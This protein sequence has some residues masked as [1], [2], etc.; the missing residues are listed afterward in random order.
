MGNTSDYLAT[1]IAWNE[2]EILDQD[3]TPAD[4]VAALERL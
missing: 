4:I 3:M 1:A 2:P